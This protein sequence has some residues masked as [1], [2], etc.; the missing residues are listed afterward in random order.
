LVNKGP[1]AIYSGEKEY[2]CL[3]RSVI[4]VDAPT[5][6]VLKFCRL[7]PEMSTKK[8]LSCI[9]INRNPRYLLFLFVKVAAEYVT[10]KASCCHPGNKSRIEVIQTEINIVGSLSHEILTKCRKI[11]A[12]KDLMTVSMNLCEE[13]VVEHKTSTLLEEGYQLKGHFID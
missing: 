10:L 11:L 9:A 1:R 3:K 5:T 12:V 7:G 2:I 8:H 4:Q 13:G 6:V